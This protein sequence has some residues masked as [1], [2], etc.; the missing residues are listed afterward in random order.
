[1]ESQLVIP[2]RMLSKLFKEIRHAGVSGREGFALLLGDIKSIP[3]RVSQIYI[4]E[5]DSGRAFYKIT[6]KGDQK[7]MEYLK[8]EKL[9]V[10][11]QLHSHPNEAF[12]SDA[13]DLMATVAHVG[14]LSFV[15]PDFGEGTT[16]KNFKNLVKVYELKKGGAWIEAARETW[17][18]NDGC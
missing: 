17:S 13:D 18:L 5:Y 10:L 15:L 3:L 8:S 14:G 2:E 1:M 9:M 6:S 4:P 11:A 12:H 16:E 7:L